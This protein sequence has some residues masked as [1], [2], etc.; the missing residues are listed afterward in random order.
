MSLGEALCYAVQGNEFGMVQ[1]VLGVVAMLPVADQQRAALNHHLPDKLGFTPLHIACGHDTPST[2]ILVALLEA[3][4]DP[5]EPFLND[6]ATPLFLATNKDWEAGITLLAKSGADLN[7][8]IDPLTTPLFHACKE[9]K[10]NAVKSLVKAGAKVDDEQ[11]TLMSPLGMACMKGHTS[12]V[13]MLVGSGA[14]VNRAVGPMVTPFELAIAQNHADVVSVLI[15]AG[16]DIEKEFA[17]RKL[18]TPLTA[19]CFGG[20]AEIVKILIE[21]G[22]DLEHP[23]ARN[24]TGLVCATQTGNEKTVEMM[25]HAGADRTHK[26]NDRLPREFGVVAGFPKIIEMYDTIQPP[27][28]V[29]KLEEGT[30]CIVCNRIAN[31]RC[32]RCQAIPYCSQVCQRGHWKSH[33]PFCIAVNAPN[34]FTLLMRGINQIVQKWFVQVKEH[35]FHLL[36]VV[37]FFVIMFLMVLH[38]VF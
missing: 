21:S 36:I 16:V 28:A 22:A 6:P 12:I 9:G 10:A 30:R 27:K 3:G 35:K 1:K 31:F 33:K 8:H 17:Q 32:S 24:C 19:A 34:K 18:N 20:F 5:N 23:D 15:K 2:T 7:K 25:L 14:D 38:F 37:S 4:A 11:D 29:K 26:V 13:E